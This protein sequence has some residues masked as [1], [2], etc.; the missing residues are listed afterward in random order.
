[1]ETIN[2]EVIEEINNGIKN[3][4]VVL[5]DIEAKLKEKQKQNTEKIEEGI[6]VLKKSIGLSD[7]TFDLMKQM[8]V[9]EWPT[10]FAV[11][12]TL[13][14]KAL[15]EKTEDE[16][17]TLEISNSSVDNGT[18]AEEELEKLEE[19]LEQQIKNRDDLKEELKQM[20]ENC[21]K[22]KIKL[23]KELSVTPRE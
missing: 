3:L 18:S 1:M 22:E 19:E 10:C 8:L 14:M 11:Y 4:Y 16:I 13:R 12:E 21:E 17:K 2:K 5:S 6:T 23:R 20:K 9:A 15:I 7:P